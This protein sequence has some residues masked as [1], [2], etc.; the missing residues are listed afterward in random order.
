MTIAVC[1][2]NFGPYHLAR[3]RALAAALAERGDR[4]VAY[5]VAGQEQRYP[6]S[7]AA[8]DRAV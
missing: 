8:V 1:F 6:W 5:E 4:L 2:T 3:L 7:R